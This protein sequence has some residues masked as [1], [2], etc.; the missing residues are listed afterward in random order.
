MSENGIKVEE[1]TEA[2]KSGLLKIGDIMTEEWIAAA[3]DAGATVIKAY[4]A[5]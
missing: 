2:L 4:R 3:G 5:A 1:P